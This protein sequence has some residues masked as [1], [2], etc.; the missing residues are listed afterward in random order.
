MKGGARK[1]HRKTVRAVG[2]GTGS[3][4]EV[5]GMSKVDQ[6]PV[7]LKGSPVD[8]YK[9]FSW[10]GVYLYLQSKKKKKKIETC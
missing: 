2:E 9:L 8:D 1:C 5:R 3:G 4:R 6:M 10:K 7:I